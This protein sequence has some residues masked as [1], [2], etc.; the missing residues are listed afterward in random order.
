MGG[1]VK[2]CY[3]CNRNTYIICK[4]CIMPVCSKCYLFNICKWCDINQIKHTTYRWRG[5][6]DVLS[7][8]YKKFKISFPVVNYEMMNNIINPMCVGSMCLSIC[9]NCN[10]AYPWFCKIFN[11]TIGKKFIAQNA[12]QMIS[13]ISIIREQRENQMLEQ[14]LNI[15]SNIPNE[16]CGVIIEYCKPLH[17]YEYLYIFRISKY[18]DT[19]YDSTDDRV[20]FNLERYKAEKK[21]TNSITNSITN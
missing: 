11:T 12:K 19:I 20:N 17:Y 10:T 21:I 1:S 4:Y 3:I 8:N 7:D 2:F 15:E 16:L 6:C 18:R 5:I 9:N 13:S 14:L